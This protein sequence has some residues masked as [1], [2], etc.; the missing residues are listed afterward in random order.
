[1]IEF[2][3]KIP[4]N[5]NPSNLGFATAIVEK[6]S[7]YTSDEVSLKMNNSQYVD[8]KSILGLLSLRYDIGDSIK[9]QVIG[10]NEN[11]TASNLERF[12]NKLLSLYVE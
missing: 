12:I 2:E 5:C 8:A 3:V 10:E 4:E 9:I 11:Y 7:T 1:M 6:A